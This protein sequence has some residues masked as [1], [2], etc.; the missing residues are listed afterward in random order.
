MSGNK[1]FIIS[2]KAIGLLV[3]LIVIS[4]A[5]YTCGQVTV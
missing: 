2:I 4:Y 5:L 1:L 3:A